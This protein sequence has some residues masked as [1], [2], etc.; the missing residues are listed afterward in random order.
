MNSKEPYPWRYIFSY[1]SYFLNF[2]HLYFSLLQLPVPV[3]SVVTGVAAAAGC[4]LVASSD[5]VVATPQ[6][7]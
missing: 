6:S 4:Q 1:P 3:I 7:R 2:I 5:I